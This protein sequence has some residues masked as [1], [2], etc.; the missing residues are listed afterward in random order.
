MNDMW[1][2]RRKHVKRKTKNRILVKYIGVVISLSLE[3]S[4]HIDRLDY[5]ID[6]EVEQIR[7]SEREEKRIRGSIEIPKAIKSFEGQS[8]IN[9]GIVPLQGKEQVLNVELSF[10][11]I[12]FAERI[13]EENEYPYSYVFSAGGFII[14]I[15]SVEVISIFTDKDSEYFKISVS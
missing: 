9:L 2:N 14:R 1:Y 11:A 13:N 5:N 12:L 3:I 10:N 15:E 7:F 8:E 6:T 4:G